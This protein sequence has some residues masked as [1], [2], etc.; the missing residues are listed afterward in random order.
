MK[1]YRIS[2][3]LYEWQFQKLIHDFSRFLCV[4]V[5]SHS[6]S[7]LFAAL[8]F[9][10]LTYS[11]R[12]LLILLSL[13]NAKIITM[14][15]LAWKCANNTKQKT[16]K[17]IQKPTRQFCIRWSHT[18][19]REK[20]DQT[21]KKGNFYAHLKRAIIWPFDRR[22]LTIQWPWMYALTMNYKH[23][24]T[25]IVFLLFF[26][27]R[28]KCACN[29]K[30]REK[31]T[32]TVRFRLRTVFGV[33]R[34]G[35]NK[36][37]KSSTRWDVVL[38]HSEID[39]MRTPNSVILSSWWMSSVVVWMFT[40]FFI[41]FFNS[42]LTLL[43]CYLATPRHIYVI[44]NTCVTFRHIFAPFLALCSGRVQTP[45][46]LHLFLRNIIPFIFLFLLLFAAHLVWVIQLP[47]IWQNQM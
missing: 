44:A 28:S 39:W 27:T 26:V 15:A 11:W 14:A 46:A 12:V 19:W 2:S 8:C 29:L 38:S 33:P 21:K 17:W 7:P 1:I 34:Q 45:V 20:N 41:V 18:L 37:N 10:R 40:I 47:F 6:V 36:W 24:H 35:K 43:S 22:M 3:I 32:T 16:L 4:C 25:N 30:R 42:V 31:W 5:A 9:N 23:T 13:S